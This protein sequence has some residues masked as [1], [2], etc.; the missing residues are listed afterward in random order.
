MVNDCSVQ[1]QKQKLDDDS[2]RDKEKVRKDADNLTSSNEMEFQS[3][4]S[5]FTGV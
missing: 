5:D 2:W 4:L 1:S 3:S